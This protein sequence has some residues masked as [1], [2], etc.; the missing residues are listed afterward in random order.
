MSS[1]PAKKIN[2]MKIK[3]YT[4]HI[5]STS[6]FSKTNSVAYTSAFVIFV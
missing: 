1:E 3:Y 5:A 2:K 4:S 6:Q